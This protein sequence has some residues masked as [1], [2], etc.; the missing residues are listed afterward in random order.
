MDRV[1]PTKFPLRADGV[2]IDIDSKRWNNEHFWDSILG[3]HR[4]SRKFRRPPTPLPNFHLLHL[5]TTVSFERISA[6]KML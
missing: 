1:D 6:Y 2:D 5:P 3:P 4:I